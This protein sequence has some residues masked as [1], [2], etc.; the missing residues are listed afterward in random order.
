MKIN[1]LFIGFLV[2]FVFLLGWSKSNKGLYLHVR[3][4]RN[5]SGT[6]IVA[7]VDKSHRKYREARS[8]GVSS[9]EKE[10]EQFV[11]EGKQ[12]IDEQCKGLDMFAQRAQEIE[13]QYLPAR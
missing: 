9:E 11:R 12:W 1:L 7:Q 5:R 10:I 8:F 6:V 13:E 3:Q 2:Y 4:K